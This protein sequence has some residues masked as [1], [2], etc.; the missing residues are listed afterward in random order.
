MVSS[1]SDVGVFSDQ[2]IWGHKLQIYI[3]Q[4]IYRQSQKS[5]W[6]KT[7]ALSKTRWEWHHNTF[8]PSLHLVPF[9]QLCLLFAIC[10]VE[11]VV[12]Y[13]YVVHVDVLGEVMLWV[14][15]KHSKCSTQK[16]WSAEQC[17][18]CIAYW[19]VSYAMN[20]C[21]CWTWHIWSSCMWKAVK[22]AVLSALLVR[23]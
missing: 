21:C 23:S 4:T 16:L 9:C 8:T 20:F 11:W 6:T 10:A 2:T 14:T 15:T 5:F 12:L 3:Q 1:C 7:S 22:W 17:W 18:V 13:G 19:S